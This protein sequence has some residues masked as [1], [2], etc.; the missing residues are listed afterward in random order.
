L[1]EIVQYLKHVTA[2]V[3]TAFPQ[4]I[5]SFVSLELISLEDH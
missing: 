5:G 4:L 1:N 3:I 2:V